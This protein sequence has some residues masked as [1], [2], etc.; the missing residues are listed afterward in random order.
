MRESCPRKTKGLHGRIWIRR[1]LDMPL[2][3]NPGHFQELFTGGGSVLEAR[4]DIGVNI[5]PG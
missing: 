2:H 3:G 4:Q 5:G 1:S